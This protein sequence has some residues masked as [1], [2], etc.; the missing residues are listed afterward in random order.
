LTIIWNIFTSYA[1]F[2][3]YLKQTF[4]DIDAEATA[5]RRLK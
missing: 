4:G 5:K 3:Q 1:G 2:R